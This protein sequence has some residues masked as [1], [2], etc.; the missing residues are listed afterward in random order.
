MAGAASVPGKFVYL[1]PRPEAVEQ[2]AFMRRWRQ[3][4]DLNMGM[5]YFERFTRYEQCGTLTPA[6]DPG[7]PEALFGPGG[8]TQEFGGV[9]L[10]WFDGGAGTL[11]DLAADPD[12]A[13]ALADEVGTFGGRLGDDLLATEE[14]VI[15]DHGGAQL[16]IFS[17]LQRQKGLSL[18]EFADQWRAFA[19]TFAAH[20]E[21]TRHC[22]G[23]V[24]NHV[25]APEGAPKH[26]GVA[27]MR[28]RS[29]ADVVAFVSEPSLVEE[30]FPAEEPFIDRTDVVV[31]LTRPTVLLDRSGARAGS[32]A[33]AG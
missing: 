20:Q 24:Q 16:K 13:T 17:F 11:A 6:D 30:L 10:A 12:A 19:D 8:I 32:A 28:F 25:Y 23:Y 21:L 14:E 1:A 26:D 2:A 3:H 9:G 31:I 33:Q 18:A 4:G 29:I 5:S 22:C 15:Y 27:E 7:L